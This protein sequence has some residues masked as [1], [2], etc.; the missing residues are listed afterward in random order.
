VAFL[1]AALGQREELGGRVSEE[2]S[3]SGMKW[4]SRDRRSKEVARMFIISWSDD[5]TLL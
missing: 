1:L 3:V 4:T 2:D 5:L